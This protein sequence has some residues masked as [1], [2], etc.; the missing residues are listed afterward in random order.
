MKKF[1]IK[2]SAQKGSLMVEAIALLGLITMVTP[3]LYK[4]AA[5]RTTELQDINTATQMRMVSKA[6]DDYL[7]DN[8][9]TVGESHSSDEVWSLS[10]EERKKLADYLP[11][12]FNLDSSKLF[13]EF[14]IAVKRRTVADQNG[15]DHHIYTSAVLAPLKEDLTMMRSSKI[16]SMIGANGGV[17]RQIG[18]DYKLSGVQGTWE[19]NLSDY[20]F[21]DDGVAEGSLAIVSTEAISSASGGANPNE[22]LYR[23]DV[24]DETKNTME[25]TLYMD[26]Y[27]IEQVK[28]LIAESGTGAVTIGDDSRDSNL[29]VKGLTTLEDMVSAYTGVEIGTSGETASS[30]LL[31]VYGGTQVGGALNVDGDT[32]LKGTTIDGNISQN[33]GQ[34]QF[35]VGSNGFSVSAD[36]GSI[37]MAGAKATI[38]ATSDAIITA[39]GKAKIG[40]GA[41][42][43]LTVDNEGN[44][45]Q[46]P[47]VFDDITANTI[48]ANTKFRTASDGF[49]AENDGSVIAQSLNVAGGTVIA[50]EHGIVVNNNGTLNV[51]DNLLADEDS[52][53]VA[54][55]DFAVG[56]GVNTGGNKININDTG[57]FIGYNYNNTDSEGL[58]VTSGSLVL[59]NSGGKLKVESGNKV[60]LDN[61]DSRLKM[62][63]ESVVIGVGTEDREKAKIVADIS[64]V[65]F[66]NNISDNAYSVYLDQ[67]DLT[68]ASKGFVV[69]EYGL[70]IGGIGG[71]I[72]SEK[73]VNVDASGTLNAQS[74][75]NGSKIAISRKGILEVAAPTDASDTGGFIRARRLVS[76]VPYQSADQYHGFNIS[77]GTPSK[78]YDYYQVNPAYTSVMNDIKL[79]SRGG[80]RLSDI[81]P[82]FINKGIYV[83]D[84][85]YKESALPEDSWPAVDSAGVVKVDGAE[86][87][88][89][90]DCDN[91]ACLASPWLGFV[92]AP[93]CPK[94]YSKVV[95]ISP[96]R[97][98]MSEVFSVWPDEEFKSDDYKGANYEKMLKEDFGNYFYQPR[99]PK[100]A[101]YTLTDQI[102]TEGESHTHLIDTGHAM[103]FQTNTFLNTTMEPIFASGG[104]DADHLIGWHAVMGFIY[105]PQI[106]SKLI[107]DILNGSPDNDEIYWN[108]FPVY[109]QDMAGIANVYCAFDRY[110]FEGNN[111]KW[112]LESPVYDYDQIKNYRFGNAKSGWE[113]TVNDPTLGYDDVW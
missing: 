5:E 89:S 64:K 51:R 57:A 85:T 99:D 70:A 2:E 71:D 31:T 25:T 82:D 103:T 79:A 78:R 77:G 48:T 108:V 112:G 107:G 54:N 88:T 49:V 111:W 68:V 7:K 52:V 97:W 16:A 92:P 9:H 44:K 36:G 80:A 109:A 21:S 91:T 12:G 75:L 13:D 20:G 90:H 14:D 33:N 102:T 83:V 40:I 66:E 84:N 100:K 113:D 62:D 28:N 24:G 60:V 11:H 22:V 59:Q 98:R 38:S 41:G 69:D 81:L 63:G 27:P 94:G 61:N 26:G 74:I 43:G 47:T 86:L 37:S 23:A 67:G 101:E 110:D 18:E 56:G 30:N 72:S 55:N 4:K 1:D 105:R 95:T 106:Y 46:G 8:Y 32:T 76:D 15:V 58:Y 104:E 65:G 6:V 96:F 35:N 10:E 73:S 29:L 45:F 3:I 17:Y 42:Y 93:Q 39:D 34:A 50:D 19:A 87:S 53:H